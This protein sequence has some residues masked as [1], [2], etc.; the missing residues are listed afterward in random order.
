[1]AKKF[2]KILK[3]GGSSVGSAERIKNVCRIISESAK[4]GRIAVVVSAM[5]GITDKLLALDLK[6]VK[7]KHLATA[8][9]LKISPP[10]ELLTELENVVEG[11][12]KIGD[13]SPMALDLVASFGEQLSAELVARYL[14]KKIRAVAVDA[15][16]LIKTDENFQNAAVDFPKT[17]S[18]IRSFFSKVRGVPVITGFIGSTD[19][20]KTTTLGRGG[21]DYSAAL[22]GAA[23]NTKV[24]EIWTDADGIMTAD[25]RIVPFAFT[26]PQI[27][28]EEA[29]EMAYF[30]AKV[31]HPVT[32]VPAIKKGIPILIKNTFNPT[33]SGTLILKDPRKEDRIV[34]N[35][36]AID[37]VTLIDVG[38]TDLAGHPGTAERVF[39]AVAAK[40]VNVVL[41]AQA[42][43]EHTICFAIRKGDGDRVMA[44]LRGEFS[45]EM[46]KGKMRIG[47]KDSQSIVAVVG[48]RMRGVPGIAGKIF[49][50][51]GGYKINISAIAQGGSERN[52][53]CVISE[54]D[55]EKAILAIHREFFQ[56]NEKPAIFLLGVGNVGSELLHQIIQ[57]KSQE[58]DQFRI[59][60]IANAEKMH[61]DQSGIDLKK[62]KK[63]IEKTQEKTDLTKLL[64]KIKNFDG[65]KIFVDCTASETVAKKYPEFV[66]AGCHIVTP[67]KKANVLPMA[68]YITL[69]KLLEKHNKTFQYQ[70]NVGAGLPIIETVKNLSS[71]GDDIKKIEGVLSG[72][73]S[74]LFN[75]YDG[76]KKFSEL[77]REA[78]DKGYTEPDPREDLNGQ[79][80]GRKLLILAREAGWLVELSNVGLENL[81]K[82]SDEEILAKLEK[83]KSRKCVLRY[84]GVFQKGKLSAKL[85]EVPLDHSL[86]NVTGTDNVV[87]IYTSHYKNQPLVIKGPG[88]GAEVTAAAVLRGI[89]RVIQNHD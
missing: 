69:R 2:K 87:A 29:F 15:R 18:K 70:A 44:A 55:K 81:A 85:K 77:V 21:S 12:K 54:K 11:I 76:S 5:Q 88:A 28:Y 42:S 13:A 46:A 9:K 7:E 53:S 34:K 52:I 40:K 17:N 74:Y 36:S 58:P 22:F 84:V 35:I 47:K 89:I 86:A 49:G 43:S 39:K 57:N 38:G 56:K 64:Q 27:S 30:G 20:G 66:A 16:Q 73:L 4:S 41:I 14:A 51:L 32:M 50:V 6:S 75:H 23:L 72:T 24:I 1:M 31:I 8:S 48:E 19:S 67:N 61:F 80:V 62:W 78:K 59:C 79:D 10:T 83:A 65:K 37:G 26:L 25:P 3:F 63:L 82:Y 33:H 60:G 71:A 45:T 68:K